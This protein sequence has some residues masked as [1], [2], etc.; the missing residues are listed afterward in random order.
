[1]HRPY[2]QAKSRHSG[3]PYRLAEHAATDKLDAGNLHD[4]SV[5]PKQG[6]F[7]EQEEP[8]HPS[9]TPKKRVRDADLERV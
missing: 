6:D 3:L 8:D 7:H 4:S 1:M 5:L 9:A 2:M